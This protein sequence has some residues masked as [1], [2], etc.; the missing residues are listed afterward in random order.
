MNTW[1]AVRAPLRAG[2]T[3]QAPDGVRRTP[4]DAGP[5]KV[6]LSSTAAPYEEML[7][8]KLPSDEAAALRTFYNA[9]KA[10]RFTFTHPKYGAGEALF[11]GPISWSE[12]AFFDI[13]SVQLKF[14]P[15]P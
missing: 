9:N 3:S 6:R 13:A 7:R 10:L 2:W 15:N 12:E 1:P 5:D 8:F 4:M 14:W 11:A